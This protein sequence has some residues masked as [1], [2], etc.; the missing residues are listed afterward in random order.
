[1]LVYVPSWALISQQGVHFL[2]NAASGS[3]R[4]NGA[5]GLLGKASRVLESLV[6]IPAKTLR[7]EAVAAA[8]RL[9]KLLKLRAC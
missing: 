1:M 9:H 2:F 4:L 8:E 6:N 5:S 7:L 3:A